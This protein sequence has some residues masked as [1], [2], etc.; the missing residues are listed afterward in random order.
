METHK[1]QVCGFFLVIFVVC[2]YCQG[3]CV[4]IHIDDIIV[5]LIFGFVGFAIPGVLTIW[6]IYNCF[7]ICFDEAGDWYEQV[8]IFQYHYSISSEYSGI[9]WISL[10]GLIGYFILLFFKASK[11]PPLISAISISM[12]IFLIFMHCSSRRTQKDCIKDPL[13]V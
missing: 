7:S 6:N 12:I 13:C 3:G 4:L 11:L 5:W 10:I 2:L 9:I 8:T 1:H